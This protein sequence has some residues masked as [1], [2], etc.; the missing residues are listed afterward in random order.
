M[1]DGRAAAWRADVLF[2]LLILAVVGLGVRMALL[3]RDGGDAA[4]R[5]HVQQ[6]KVVPLPARPGNIYARTRGGYVLLAGSRQVPSAF[7]D[8]V[9]LRDDELLDIAIDVGRALDL[10]PAAVQRTFI[11][12]RGDRFVWLKRDISD[13]EVAGVRGIPTPA[14]SIQHEWRRYYPNNELGATVLGFRLHDG[15]GGGGIELSWNEC[16]AARAGRRTMLADARR[17]SIWPL[18]E[19]SDPPR[20]GGQVFLTIDAVIQASLQDAIRR[21]VETHDAR[22][23]AGVVL[24]CRTGDVLAMASVPT[25]DPNRFNR[26]DPADR[27]NRAI[28][29]P[30]EPGSALKPVFAAAAVQAGV[31]DFDTRIFCE[32]GV[33]HARRGGRITDHGHHYGWLTLT[34]VVVHS[35]NIGMAK[36]GE[37]LGNERLHAVA[38]RFG[39]GEPTGVDLPGESGGIVRDLAKWDGYSLRRVPFGQEISV[40]TLQLATAFNALVNGGLLM[41]PRVVDQV[42][43]A[44]GNVVWRGEPRVVRRVLTPQVSAQAVDVLRQVVERGTGKRCK[45]DR[46]TSF[47]KTGTAQIPGPGG[48]PAG[49][50]TGTFVG[51]APAGDPRVLCVISIYYPDASKG[52]YGSVVAARYVRDVLAR[53]L[54]Y[55]DVPP[56]RTTDLQYAGR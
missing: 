52:Y 4:R 51:G 9:T 35:S 19:E 32:N 21:S 10:D 34:D 26:T 25:Y 15:R 31:V 24:D 36:V 7:V 37:M 1:K 5:V 13:A 40:T 20:D 2:G 11:T 29:M 44:S 54:S 14:V 48:Y 22:W 49:A 8:P 53:S 28:V 41:Q 30:Y 23:G 55:L 42:R 16:L 47:G 46:W 50:Y 38:R 27:T 39:F 43:D 3:I 18:P 17:R 56:D 6:R 45:L 33:Y 12:R